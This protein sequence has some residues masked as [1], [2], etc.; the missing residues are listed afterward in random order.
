MKAAELVLVGLGTLFTLIHP[1]VVAQASSEQND[2]P[3]KNKVLRIF[4]ISL[5]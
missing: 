4:K 1:P 5:L 3:I 2:S